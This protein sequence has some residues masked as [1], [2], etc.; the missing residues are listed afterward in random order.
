MNHGKG[1]ASE[2]HRNN[3]FSDPDAGPSLIS[4]IAPEEDSG[5][6]KIVHT[7]EHRFVIAVDYGTTYTGV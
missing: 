1:R 6:E 3:P 2:P 5:E 4:L 7:R